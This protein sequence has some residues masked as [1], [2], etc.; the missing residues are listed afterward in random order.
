MRQ[1][2]K[3]G[4]YAGYDKNNKEREALDYYATPIKEVENIIHKLGLENFSGV[5]LEPSCGGG[6]MVEGILNTIP[7]STIIA[8]DIQKR[9]NNF[10]A[11]H[12]EKGVKYMYGKEYDF[13][14]DDYPV[15]NA[16]LIIMNPPFKVIVPFILHS[17]EIAEKGVLCFGRTKLVEGI[18]RYE[19]IFSTIPPTDIY[20][21]IDRVTCGK[22][23]DFDGKNGV[24]AHAWF[25]WDKEKINKENDWDTKFHWIFTS[26]RN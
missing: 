5:I 16:D 24:E 9:P 3:I 6:H 22:N 15:K 19:K 25:Y 17:F 23:G 4:S 13:L 1:Y 20:Q 7:N 14:S 11:S 8:T 10:L 26:G 21:Y 2:S 12:F 18:E